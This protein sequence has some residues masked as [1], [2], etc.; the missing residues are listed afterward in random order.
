MGLKVEI[1]LSES[2]V[3]LLVK[4]I[5]HTLLSHFWDFLFHPLKCLKF[6]VSLITLPLKHIPQNIS[7]VEI[8]CAV[9]S[10]LLLCTIITMMTCQKE[11]LLCA[12]TGA[13][14]DRLYLVQ[15]MVLQSWA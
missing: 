4:L 1:L 5:K 14:Y 8:P 11:R 3:T 9:C 13:L 15:V 10:T 6:S 2:I 12:N 7:V